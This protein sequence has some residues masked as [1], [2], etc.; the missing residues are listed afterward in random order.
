MIDSY[1]GSVKKMIPLLDLDKLFVRSEG[2]ECVNDITGAITNFTEHVNNKLFFNMDGQLEFSASC[3]CGK[4][5]G[6][7]Y[8]DWRCGNCG[9]IVSSEFIDHLSHKNWIG[10]PKGMPMVLHPIVY[11]VLRNFL[12]KVSHTYLLDILL[13]PTLELP[14]P[15]KPFIHG[16][17]YTYFYNNYADILEFF[18][19]KYPKTVKNAKNNPYYK[20]FFHM[21]HDIVFCTKLPLLDPVLHPVSKS[22][23]NK[24]SIDAVASHALNAI[25]TLT[26]S[27]YEKQKSITSKK[28]VDK[29][30]WKTYSNY[31]AYVEAIIDKKLGGKY[32]H[33]RK[34]M[35]GIRTH[36]SFRSVIV[37]HTKCHMADEIKLPWTIGVHTFKLHVLNHLVNRHKYSYANATLKISQALVKHDKFIHQILDDILREAPTRRWPNEEHSAYMNS[38]F[39]AKILF[40]RNPSLTHGSIFKLRVVGFKEDINDNTIE[41]SQLIVSP[42]N[43]DYDGDEMYGILLFENEMATT[44]NTLHPKEMIMSKNT[45][46]VDTKI[47]LTVPA[48]LTVNSWFSEEE[49]KLTQEGFDF[50]AIPAVNLQ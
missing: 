2:A 4:L 31:I 50:S 43:A 46:T 21:Y 37:P 40:G 41:F 10:I 48:M 18:F 24:I 3:E 45:P 49:R 6:N 38:D 22:G 28:F 7:Y 1:V 35:Y 17:G 13:N 11:L 34:Q 44:F 27:V 19:T 26:Y 47:K 12:G 25:T 15:I 30:L 33:L 9:T 20:Q 36:F 23:V 29:A 14:A 5:Q 16:Q 39:G 8:E 42:P 32:G